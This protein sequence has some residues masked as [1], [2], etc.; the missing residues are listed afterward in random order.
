MVKKVGS[1]GNEGP[2]ADDTFVTLLIYPPVLVDPC[3]CFD[4]A[5]LYDLNLLLSTISCIFK[6]VPFLIRCA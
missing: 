1:G 6:I 3:P 5:T 4:C 2:H